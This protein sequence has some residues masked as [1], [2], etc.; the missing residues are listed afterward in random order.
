V[1]GK[2][3]SGMN[4]NTGGDQEKGEKPTKR[5]GVRRTTRKST[6]KMPQ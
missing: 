3:K 1:L 6:L 4:K 2:K 5:K